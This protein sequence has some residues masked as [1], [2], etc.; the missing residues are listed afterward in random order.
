MFIEIQ[1]LTLIY[2]EIDN[3]LSHLFDIFWHLCVKHY[4]DKIR[5]I[6]QCCFGICHL[7]ET[8]IK[9]HIRY[10]VLYFATASNGE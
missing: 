10:Y 4:G 9:Y 1:D 7:K 6:H 5:Q 8:L 2:S 3:Y